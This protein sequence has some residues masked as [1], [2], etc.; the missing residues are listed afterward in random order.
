MLKN[1]LKQLIFGGALLIGFFLFFVNLYGLTQDIRPG[2]FLSEDIR[3]ENDRKPIVY[4]PEI[5]QKLFAGEKEPKQFTTDI[6]MLISKILVHIEWPKVDRVQYNQL[7]PIWE[8][9]F[10]YFMGLFSDI[11]EFERYHYSNYE[12]SLER[13]IGICGDASMIL[14]QVLDKNSIENKILSFPGHVINSVT[15]P[16]GSQWLLDA[17]FGVV[18]PHS[19]SEIRDNIDLVKPYYAEQGYSDREIGNL[20]RS[21]I[22]DFQTWDGVTHF[23]TKK[24]YFEKITYWLKWPLPIVLILFSIYMLRK[25]DNS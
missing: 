19:L 25:R 14:S 11:P 5:E 9:Y 15:F 22:S 1:Y 10:L 3:F 6:T 21:Y 8:N 4:N 13:G 17:D 12:R 2:T 18:I 16:D 24:Y 23:F 7:I 20:Q